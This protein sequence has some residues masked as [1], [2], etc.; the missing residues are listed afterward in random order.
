MSGFLHY[1]GR[2]TIF[3][4]VVGKE[5]RGWIIEQVCWVFFFLDSLSSDLI[6]ALGELG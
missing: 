1:V 2:K 3:T 4:A 5:D 6:R